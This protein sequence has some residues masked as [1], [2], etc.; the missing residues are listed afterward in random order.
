MT[1]A[2]ITRRAL[3]ALLD[4]GL[5]VGGTPH[6]VRRA[7]PADL[8]DPA[9]GVV[10]E[11]LA[12][13]P[14][15]GSAPGR[16]LR[17]ATLRGDRVDVPEV[18]PVLGR[19]PEHG[20]VGLRPGK[21]AVW[22]DARGRYVK[23]A[24]PRATRR[25]ARRAETIEDLLAGLPGAPGRPLLVHADVGAAHLTWAP[26]EG[27]ELRAVLHSGEEHAAADAGRRVGA[28][29]VTLAGTLP[30]P[31]DLSR[32]D[33]PVHTGTEE[34]QILRRWA[35]SALA[36]APLT[37]EESD[38]LRTQV[39]RVAR[40]L[41]EE[42]APG[43]AL[44]LAHRDLHDG[45]VLVGDAS[46]TF[47]DWDTAAWAEPV[48][49]VANLLAHVD[50]CARDFDGD[51]DGAARRCAAFTAAL[52]DSL[53]AGGHPAGADAVAARLRGAREATALRL[54]AVHAFRPRHDR[55]EGCHP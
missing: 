53:R 35:A 2:E 10:L 42:S 8:D 4:E 25:A 31:G 27:T 54:L 46:V 40:R 6:V 50:R 38:R 49:D 37:D 55:H 14:D 1:A 39:P 45:Q 28:A 32:S 16:R 34:A 19:L 5:T 47:L 22:R 51:F 41:A 36:L 33:L 52:G 23:A 18:D 17:G 11:L 20:L 29:L 3:A 21:R 30:P 9:A 44:V 48:L 26:A 24:R 12:R 43:P 7:W 13:A 15:G